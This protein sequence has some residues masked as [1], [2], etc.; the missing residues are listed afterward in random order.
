[1]AYGEMKLLAPDS[2]PF[3]KIGHCLLRFARRDATSRLLIDD[4]NVEPVGAGRMDER[5]GVPNQG[6]LGW[7]R[8]Q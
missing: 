2:G 8:H 4:G 6:Y 5:A 1:M 3:R 7:M